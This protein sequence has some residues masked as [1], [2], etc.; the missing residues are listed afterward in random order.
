MTYLQ[1][2]YDAWYRGLRREPATGWR[3]WR[4]VGDR[5]VSPHFDIPLPANGIAV[6]VCGEDHDPPGVACECGM[7][8][9]P[10]A[11]DIRG[12]LKFGPSRD[13]YDV[14]IAAVTFGSITGPA[15]PGVVPYFHLL[16]CAAYEVAVVVMDSKQPLAYDVPVIREPWET[17]RGL[18]DSIAVM[19]S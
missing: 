11:N 5:L 18:L 8:V 4:L 15:L 14:G 17:A 16:R 3:V 9:L 10:Y 7:N 12:Y 6:A 19:A 13:A 2:T 1:A